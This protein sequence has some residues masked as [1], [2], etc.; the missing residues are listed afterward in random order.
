MSD[1]VVADLQ[2]FKPKGDARWAY[3]FRAPEG[4]PG[5]RRPMGRGFGTRREA[6][7]LRSSGSP[8]FAPLSMSGRICPRCRRSSPTISCFV[9]EREADVSGLSGRWQRSR[10]VLDQLRSTR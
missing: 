5:A 3:R 6:L 10:V 7:K 9:R 4:A 2:V 1:T 8:R